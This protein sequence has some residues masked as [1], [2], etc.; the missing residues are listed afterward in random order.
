M[1][2]K[3]TNGV[4]GVQEPVAPVSPATPSSC[5]EDKKDGCCHGRK[6][7]CCSDVS[8]GRKLLMTFVGI[9]LVYL[10]VLLG[11]LIR[12]YIKK[13]DYI[14]RTDRMERTIAVEAQGK[15]AATPNIAMVTV[16]MNNEDKTVADAQKK[17]TEVMNSLMAKLTEFGI[18]KKD[19]QTTSY[20]IYPKYTWTE[21]KG[22]EITGYQVDQQVSV[23]IRQLD[24]AS[25]ILEA[26]GQVGANNVSGLQFTIDDKDVYLAQ[27]REEAMKKIAEKAKLLS[28]KLGVRLVA[29]YAYDEYE[30]TSGGYDM[31]S[32]NLDLM[33]RGGVEGATP[34]LSEGTS[35]VIMN[36]RVTFEMR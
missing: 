4:I 8:F 13:Y 14:G 5:C 34:T 12:N 33:G 30:V 15:V 35:D 22:D 2:V 11:V 24:K 31:Y 27:A 25:Q 32:A 36:V 19:I 21:E 6:S 26:V 16:G 3:K 18:E 20:N 29:V 7:S 28:S 1:P 9:L 17:N 10:I 23:K